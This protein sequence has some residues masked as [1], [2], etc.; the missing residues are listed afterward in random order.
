MSRCVT[1]KTLNRLLDGDLSWPLED[2]VR[3][4]VAECPDCARLLEE[5]QGVDNVIR[6]FRASAPGTPDIA[7]R[8]VRE[9]QRRGAFVRARVA[10]ARRGL[11]GERVI[12]GRMA[13]AVS[14][15][16]SLLVMAMFGMDYLSA[17]SWAHRTAPVL[18]DAERVLV[19][20]V[21][22]DSAADGGRLARARDEARELGLS[23]RLAEARV[24]AAT[25]SAAE[26]L[27]YLEETFTL[28]ASGGPIS[29]DMHERLSVGEALQ[30]ATRLREALAPGG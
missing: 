15:A 27:A 30:R 14:V 4:H 28:L 2:R 3:R 26:D 24:A 10:S 7:A 20:L 19:R 12:W 18:A 5:M 11:L 9:L 8:V 13:A 17:H 25:P 23:A 6:K 16:A 22:V 21:S 29:S 1:G